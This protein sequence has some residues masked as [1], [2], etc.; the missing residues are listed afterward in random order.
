[1]QANSP[2]TERATMNQ[3]NRELRPVVSLWTAAAT[4]VGVSAATL[5]LAKA[6]P[7]FMEISGA[8]F[9]GR[10]ALATICLAGFVAAH[11]GVRKALLTCDRTCSDQEFRA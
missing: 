1:M 7:M 9:D 8:G 10:L 3:D 2:A 5:V 6:P 11:R 4:C